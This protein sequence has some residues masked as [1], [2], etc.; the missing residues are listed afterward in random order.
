MKKCTLFLL[1][2][3]I[4]SFTARSQ[5]E[6]KM[7]MDFFTFDDSTHYYNLIIDPFNHNNDWQTGQPQ[8]TFFNQAASLPNVLITDT[9]GYYKPSNTSVVT[10][11]SPTLGYGFWPVVE[12]Y[13]EF[14]SDSLLDYGKIEVSPDHGQTWIDIVKDAN[15]HGFSWY[16]NGSLGG[17]L[18][19]NGD[20][21]YPFTG[22]TSGWYYYFRSD[23]YNFY[24]QFPSADTIIYRFSFISDAIQTN[25]EGWMIDNLFF[26]DWWE[27]ITPHT[28]GDLITSV[29][30]NP[31]NAEMTIRFM[32][33]S[34][35]MIR[36][37]LFDSKGT[38]ISTLNTTSD[39]AK[40]N[41][42]PLFA[43][44]YLYKVMN[45][46]TQQISTGRLIRE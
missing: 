2:L 4:L 22:R 10:F 5:K 19:N 17:Q 30:P 46:K 42:Q 14:D 31:V 6:T 21:V 24:Y 23:L 16:V 25:K 13:Y 7:Y 11:F 37:E 29:S 34:K 38:K 3:A 27:G 39:H 44:M 35:D 28:A 43:G 9:V 20:S 45:L 32:N 15:V 33:P 12:F 1:F 40:V 36:I 18:C 26:Y 41:T 8:K